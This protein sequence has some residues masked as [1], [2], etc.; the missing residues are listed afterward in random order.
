M[1]NIGHLAGLMAIGVWLRSRRRHKPDSSL[2]GRRCD[3][4]DI[5]PDRWSTTNGLNVFTRKERPRV[6]F[7]GS[8]N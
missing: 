4:L 3:R 1:D 5:Q 8:I 2:A 7:G 6:G